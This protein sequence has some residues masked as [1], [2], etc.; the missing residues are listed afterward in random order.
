MQQYIANFGYYTRECAIC[1]P[2]FY[3]LFIQLINTLINRLIGPKI[4]V[5][6]RLNLAV[7]CTSS[8]SMDGGF[9]VDR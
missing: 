2:D 8:D 4:E 9:W 1:F 6:E 7:N 3:E 5:I